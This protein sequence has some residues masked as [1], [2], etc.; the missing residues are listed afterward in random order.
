MRAPF[1]VPSLALS[2]AVVLGLAGPANAQFSG[3]VGSSNAV[4]QSF[5]QQ[6]SM[7]GIQQQQTFNN[8]QMNAHRTTD[9]LYNNT[10]SNPGGYIRRR[11]R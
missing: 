5:Q 9:R 1:F 4:N 8:N 7:R 2:C 10:S 6:N 11:H 3:G